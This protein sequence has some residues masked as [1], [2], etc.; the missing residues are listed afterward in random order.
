MKRKILS[1]LLCL[2]MV[3]T[4]LPTSALAVETVTVND[5]ATLRA[6]LTNAAD[7]D[8]IAIGA[9]ITIP[10]SIV[11][12]KKIT[13]DLGS[14]TLT[15]EPSAASICLRFTAGGT[16]TGSGMLTGGVPGS[17]L[18]HNAGGA[19]TIDG[20]TLSATGKQGLAV[21]NDGTLEIV[22]GTVESAS[23]YAVLNYGVASVTG[24]TVI[25]ATGV[26]VLNY[27]AA[28]RLTLS[29]GT[30][31]TTSQSEPNTYGAYNNAAGAEITVENGSTVTAGSGFA[32]GN[33]N[34]GTITV[35]GGVISATSGSTVLNDGDSSTAVHGG[36]IS[37]TSGSALMNYGNLLVDGGEILSST[38]LA[39][40]N[41]AKG[42]TSVTLSGGFLTSNGYTA[43]NNQDSGDILLSGS[44]V[45]AGGTSPAVVNFSTGTVSVERGV[46]T[47][48]GSIPTF[49][50]ISNGRF[51]LSGGTYYGVYNADTNGKAVID[52]GS[53][54]TFT[55]V[56]PMNSAGEVLQKYT[57][58]LDGAGANTAVSGSDLIFTP[59]VS[60]GFTDVRTD[61]NGRLYLWLPA[62]ISSATYKTE[63]VDISGSITGG[64]ESTLPNAN[65]TVFVYLDDKLWTDCPAAFCPILRPTGG[66]MSTYPAPSN[67]GVFS[68]TGLDASQTY[69]VLGKALIGQAA[70]AGITLGG[71]NSSARVD[72]YTLTTVKDEG[73][74]FV[75]PVTT[76][77]VMK[78]AEIPFSASPKDGLTFDKWADADG[79]TVSDKADFQ[80]TIEGP[81]T[82]TATAKIQPYT[83]TVTVKKDDAAWADY[84]KSVVLSP[85]STDGHAAGYVSVSPV[86]GECSFADLTQT[87]YV[88]VDDKCTGQTITSGSN[89]ATVDYY[90][91]TVKAGENVRSVEIKNHNE[92]SIIV[93][94]GSTVSI[95]ATADTE[96]GKVFS[97]WNQTD[98]GALYSTKA[99]T[100]ITNL[101]APV[102]LTAVGV[103]TTYTATVTVKLG[104][105]PWIEGATYVGYTYPA[106]RKIALSTSKTEMG[107]IT[108]TLAD[109][110]YTFQGL[111]GKTTYY[112]WD[113]ETMQ[114]TGVELSAGAKDKTLNYWR[115]LVT[116][117]VNPTCATATGTGIYLDS[118]KATAAITPDV[119][120]T[121]LGTDEWTKD[122][123]GTF[124]RIWGTGKDCTNWEFKVAILPDYYQGEITLKLDVGAYTEQT[125]TLKYT[126]DQ[127]V[128]KTVTTTGTN[129]VYKTEPVQLQ[130]SKGL[131]PDTTYKIFVNDKD[132]GKTITY[133]ARSAEV[134]YYTVSV[135][136][137][138]ASVTVDSV[139]YSDPV[140]VLKGGSA[141]FTA[142]P[143][144]GD[145]VG[146]YD[147]TTLLSTN[148]T[149]TLSNVTKATTLTAKA[150]NAFDAVITVKG[151]TDRTI[152]L[153]SGSETA[154]S[155]NE[156]TTFK[157]LDRSK[158]YKVLDGGDD[159]GLSVS[160]NAPNA[161]LQY[162]SVTVSGGTGISTATGNGTYLAGSNVTINA[163]V[164]TEYTFTG[165]GGTASFTGASAT[166]GGI[167]KDYTLTASAVLSYT[168][169]LDIS[170]GNIE[171]Y[172]SEANGKIAIKQGGTPIADAQE[173]DPTANITIT[174]TSANA[175][176]ITAT[177]GVY[178]TLKDVSI[179]RSGAPALE[180]NSAS[181]TVVLDLQGRNVLQAQGGYD[182]KAGLY[183]G[184]TDSN[185]IIQSTG[186][187]SVLEAFSVQGAAGIGGNFRQQTKNI[188]INGGT[189]LATGSSGGEGIGSGPNNGNSANL[190][191]T[192]GNINFDNPRSPHYNA[193]G[194]RVYKTTF[195]VPNDTDGGTDVSNKL[196]ISYQ[197]GNE[198]IY[199]GMNGVKT[200]A[201]G[202]VYAYLPAGSATATYGGQ[203]YAATVTTNGQAEFQPTYTV[204]T[205]TAQTLN[206]VTFT[207][208]VSASAFA[209]SATATVTVT[210]SGK[211][212]S[213]GTF[214]LGLTGAGI[215]GA[216]TQTV[217]VKEGQSPSNK[218]TVTFTMPSKAV[219]NL[220]LTA[221]FAADAK[222]TV[223][224]AAPDAT[225]GSVPA[226]VSYY[227]GETY[228][229][230]GNTGSLARTGYTFAG[231]DKSGEQTMGKENV[232]LIAQWTAKT[233]DVRFRND[234]VITPAQTF[235]YGVPQALT[236]NSFSKDGYTF[237]GWSTEANGARVYGDKQKISIAAATDLYALWT[238]NTY[239]VSFDGNG[240]TTGSMDSITVD[241]GASKELPANTF[242]KTGYTFAG[243]KDR[244]DNA[245]INGGKIS[246]TAGT[247]LT[248]QWTAN[249]YT[250][251]FGANGGTG[252]MSNQP[253]T[254]DAEKTLTANSFNRKGYTFAGWAVST[255][256]DMMHLNNANVKNLTEVPNATITLY[257]KWTAVDSV[258]TF[259]GNDETS[260][261]MA[262]QLF[263][264][265]EAAKEL[266]SN[267]FVK[268]GYVFDGWNTKP[269]GQGTA[270]AD[271]AV[272]GNLTDHMTLY[273]Q[274][275]KSNFTVKFGGNGGSGSMT[276]Q[277]FQT[278]ETTALKTNAF[279]KVGYTF[280]DWNT[281]QDGKGTNYDAD[282]A[283]K[284]LA[285]GT[286]DS[287]TLY[288]QWRANTYK[289]QFNANG[290]TG[291]M[292]SQDFTYDEVQKA[293]TKSTFTKDG[294]N[295]LGWAESPVSTSAEYADEQ[296]VS[297][298]TPMDDGV[299]TLY[300]IWKANT[301]QVVFDGNGADNSA[302]P[303]QSFDY[304]TAQELSQ[305]TYTREGHKFAG[306]NTQ[307]NGRGVS[308]ADKQEITNPVPDI[309]GNLTLYA[310][311]QVQSRYGLSG[312][313]LTD[314]D[315]AASISGATVTLK[316]GD[317]VLGVT[318]TD[319]NGNYS[320]TNL[321]PG[322]Y[323]VVCT[324]DG[325]T[326]TKAATVVD[327]PVTVPFTVSSTAKNSLLE[328]KKETGVSVLALV[329][330]G[331]SDVADAQSG[332]QITTVKLTVIAKAPD[333]QNSEQSAIQ[334]LAK[335]Q[336]IGMYL[337]AKLTC[338]GASI[339][340]SNNAVLKILIP[341]DF[342]SKTDLKVFRYHGTAATEL[343]E[344]SSLPESNPTDGTWYLDISG[345]QIIVYASKFST[346]AVSY[347]PVSNTSGG[348]GSSS[349]YPIVIGS[350]EH[351]KLTANKTTA[352]KGEIV[353]ITVGADSG[354]G[355]HHLV[356]TDLH[357]K[358]IV[359]TD[360][361]NHTYTFVMPD[362]AIMAS[363]VFIK[364]LTS[365]FLDVPDGAYYYD[366]VLWAVDNG[367]TNGT[368]ETTFTPNG[369]CTRA[370]TVTF[371]WRAMGNPEPKST[372]SPFTD[373]DVNAYYYKAV[374]WAAEK[375]ITKGTS[376]TTFS[377]IMNVTRGQTVTFLWRTAG[378][379]AAGTANPFA[380]VLSGAYYYDAVLWAVKEGIT[381][382]TTKT[383]FAP[384]NGCTRAQI[385]TFLY[386]Y[387]SR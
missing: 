292:I 235:T 23:G 125:V 175:V 322:S 100:T 152:T 3:F 339:G 120:Y 199:Y 55:G 244:E 101:T 333:E 288:A 189:I 66:G 334:D 387:L 252:S 365:Q 77:Q 10:S 136:A 11:I 237:G 225:G 278:G 21:Q 61:A 25:T 229:V 58:Q 19:L 335:S 300:A 114:Y 193:S 48:V 122:S 327:N 239:T 248:A 379:P 257:A 26:G 143:N 362:S 361:G 176:Y 343:T 205:P 127:N 213:Q 301:V 16:I 217:A 40:M 360:K 116:L 129:G 93:L 303:N 5:L 200:F 262:T 313:V 260:G 41:L 337:D 373:V 22:S 216:T 29:G 311:W 296:P 82:Y 39:L 140:K 253:F 243:W 209:G 113:A 57:I 211:A 145:F 219:E 108:G 123:N 273:A 133:L 62:G 221:A 258:V 177:R 246:L 330:D 135:M 250:V 345:G 110:V 289:V 4:L 226:T 222:Y 204:N 150:S 89:T 249:T 369:I 71:G 74:S 85:S 65:F 202:K 287:I 271:K 224:Y 306:W 45:T 130:Y 197:S 18:V 53:I 24:G 168:G 88:W 83:A 191:F 377:P 363:A 92:L 223:T 46:I 178:V 147:G 67:T 141:I 64:S 126:D 47:A 174:G 190:V 280:T 72:Y 323:N 324:Y 115:L 36:S 236:E 157:D 354:Y 268:T 382:G 78:G 12:S 270:Y 255:T 351:G 316:Q 156:G 117:N 169:T 332:G 349:T 352:A 37:T 56:A 210:L 215:T 96:N 186:G 103:S 181:G 307:S 370:Q 87:Y 245:Y 203:T 180:V 69:A 198:T 328:L 284:D 20:V 269:D 341:Y 207:P 153:Q 107:T 374:L 2:C 60:Y 358:A 51:V 187:N 121:I 386:R 295:F 163:T 192:G 290:A 279:A 124:T 86:D 298:L 185:L 63:K 184:Y 91:V 318:K 9:D 347:T 104:G 367:I 338:N 285:L 195:T 251:K 212:L 17:L 315:P 294:F 218:T 356:I 309:S 144:S 79:K 383:A 15:Y 385:V 368:T 165:W 230:A 42:G 228:T 256:G 111:E 170:N 342:S 302:M 297:N 231:W 291:S 38:S 376:A 348:F 94:K 305:N 27:S 14:Y 146:W 160:K 320:F 155:A 299:I 206:G 43:V 319:A 80:I 59:A 70:F 312:L 233:Y 8:T 44:T 106:T 95:S 282:A 329:V 234:G 6:A 275:I 1:L 274:W 384:V 167:N 366:A 54:Y 238:P 149:F 380:D 102:N 357:G 105:H 247:T 350:V 76:L 52:G 182:G 364:Q 272:L 201:E 30:V 310:Q 346:Y 151:A 317:K 119:K 139:N 326:V 375:G 308:Y 276:A 265:G 340:D 31:S 378:N 196:V 90:T 164:D 161:T 142:T 286:S 355:L 173:L 35:N 97:R 283:V 81:Q 148:P 68:Y 336:T 263:T 154:I 50:N 381:E 344:L 259:H 241:H 353:T 73:V 314:G 267:A 304:N 214:T 321:L 33:L 32:L 28:A 227:E 99:S 118:Q 171:I 131:N 254:Y 232:T 277:T 84:T 220:A 194:I 266:S 172:N 75:Y 112:V 34:G 98:D 109:N 331:L 49:Y 242:T 264:Y 162:Y 188:T 261:T 166:I 183:K 281:Q 240:A 137:E 359:Y 7:G 208:A 159:T 372:T 325:K 158:T 134:N 179:T 138:D 128:E 132:T 371:L 13:L 293:L